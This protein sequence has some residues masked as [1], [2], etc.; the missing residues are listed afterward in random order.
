MKQKLKKIAGI[1]LS[2][3]LG[4]FI[5]WWSVSGLTH[6]QKI[7][8]KN[9]IVNADYFWIG[10]ALV[11]GILSHLSRA[12]RWKYL[13]EPLGYKPKFLNSVFAIFIAYLVNLLIPRGGEV[14]RATTMSKYEAIPFEKVFGTIVAERVVDLI[15]L[16]LIVLGALFYQF[17]FIEQ[18]LIAKIPNNPA[19]YFMGFLICAFVVLMYF[20]IRKTENS[21]LKKI[22]NFIAGLVEGV[23]S[24][25]KMENRFAFIFHSVFI[26]AMYLLMFYLVSLAI[27]ETS[28]LSMSAVL[29]GFIGGVFGASANGGL[30]TFPYAI[31][32]VFELYSINSEKAFAFG[33]LMWSAQTIM[34]FLFGIVSLIWIPIYNKKFLG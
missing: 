21:F 16:G 1:F 14:I 9:A 2:I 18:L 23:I 12:Y 25:W 31:Q 20:K 8:I 24:I 33:W 19:V 26:W 17:S 5:I 28:N 15:L 32:K 30:G 22:R 13:L 11:I 34:V 6:A 4:I 29:S 7:D 3:G 27:P 10:W